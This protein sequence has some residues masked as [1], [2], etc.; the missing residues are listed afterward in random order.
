MAPDKTVSS[1]SGDRRSAQ[2]AAGSKQTIQEPNS[3]TE[4]RSPPELAAWTEPGWSGSS[5]NAPR[6][7]ARAPEK[8]ESRPSFFGPGQ[9]TDN[10]GSENSGALLH[11]EIWLDTSELREW[12]D[13]FLNDRQQPA[14][15]FDVF[16]DP[17]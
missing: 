2:Y 6:E 5:S 16:S 9:Q 10:T 7:A 12:M 14:G 11:G 8:G 15:I 3:R 4:R 13:G 1:G 17:R